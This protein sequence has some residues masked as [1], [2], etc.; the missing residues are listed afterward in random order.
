MS[1]KNYDKS[2]YDLDLDLLTTL[3]YLGV[4]FPRKSKL[5]GNK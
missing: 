5:L 3:Y 2:G 4:S 1:S